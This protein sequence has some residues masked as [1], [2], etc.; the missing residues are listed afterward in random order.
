MANGQQK[1]AGTPAVLKDRFN[2]YPGQALPE[3]ATGTAQAFGAED[4]RTVGK[5][6]V[7]LLVKPG[8]PHRSEHLAVMKGL[9][10]PGL[11]TLVDF[12]VVHWAPINRKVMT[13]IYQRPLG[14]G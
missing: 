12:G 1:G 10:T 13:V 8:I 11:M 3:F 4:L 2:I 9:E 7:A 5:P 14:G 6:M